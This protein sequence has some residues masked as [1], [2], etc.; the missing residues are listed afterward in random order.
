MMHASK[1][2]LNGLISHI[3]SSAKKR[4]IP[5]DLDVTDLNNLSFPCTCP[6]L[7]I[8]LGFNTGI[9]KDNS[10]SIDR[11]DSD[12]GYTIDNIIVISNRAN[13]LK[14]D[15]T[16]TELNSLSEFY[17]ELHKSMNL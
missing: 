8:P 1:K 17:T 2:N 7:G 14:R 16:L 15:A 5:F 11:I 9:P 4:G 13:I 3:K 12:L 10:Y 6:I